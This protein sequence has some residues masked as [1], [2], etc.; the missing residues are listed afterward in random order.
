MRAALLAAPVAVLPLGVGAPPP[1]PPPAA[2]SI[3]FS[4]L[5]S[6]SLSFLLL[7]EDL[8]FFLSFFLRFFF[9]PPS[10]AVALSLGL[11]G[12]GRSRFGLRGLRFAG[13]SAAAD[14]LLSSA[15][16]VSEGGE[17]Q[18]GRE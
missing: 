1:A 6:P 17:C 4:I 16:A 15:C 11:V 14:A 9:T 13:L 8:S 18:R 3:A 10:T 12:F 5:A 7:L 2:F